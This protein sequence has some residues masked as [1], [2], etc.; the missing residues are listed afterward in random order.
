MKINNY[1]DLLMCKQQLG[2]E[3]ENQKKSIYADIDFL[4]ERTNP[5]VI[6]TQA[7]SGSFKD[8]KGNM[9]VNVIQ[10]VIFLY[11]EWKN[12]GFSNEKSIPE[13]IMDTLG[14]EIK[15]KSASNSEQA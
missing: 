14:F 12:K 10:A 4:K 9:V 1:Q 5:L 2:I 6:A 11:K 3:I 7:L 15:R 8:V 13:F